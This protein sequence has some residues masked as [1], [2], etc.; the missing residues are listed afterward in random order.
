MSDLEGAL[1]QARKD[2]DEVRSS[3]QESR[4]RETQALAVAKSSQEQAVVQRAYADELALENHRLAREGADLVR[5]INNKDLSE[6]QL[7]EHIR[8]L[9]ANNVKMQK[10]MYA[11]Y[12]RAEQMQLERDSALHRWKDKEDRLNQSLH[13][14]KCENSAQA[15][16]LK[17]YE[18]ALNQ[19]NGWP[20]V[21]DS[22]HPITVPKPIGAPRGGGNVSVAAAANAQVDANLVSAHAAAK[23]AVGYDFNMPLLRSTIPSSPRYL[24]AKPYHLHTSPVVSAR[25]KLI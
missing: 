20:L 5:M 10:A 6:Q 15:D 2:A 8:N 23:T 24:N 13:V 3:E 22:A 16:R 12:A 9:D 21:A 17:R 4:A 19:L 11:T 1:N 18:D 7:T 25:V 14:L